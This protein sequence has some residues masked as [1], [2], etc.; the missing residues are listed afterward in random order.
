MNVFIYIDKLFSLPEH[1]PHG[2]TAEVQ[3]DLCLVLGSF[4]E[5]VPRVGE[6]VVLG[7]GHDLRECEV[8]EVKY[9]FTDDNYQGT[10]AV[11][12]GDHTRR[13]VPLV[14][15]LGVAINLQTV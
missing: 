6:H 9:Y 14:S 15:L 10:K 3:P 7:E 12:M 8:Q 13:R 1:L 5:S 4:A 2:D 11:V